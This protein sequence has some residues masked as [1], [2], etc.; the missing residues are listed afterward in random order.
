MIHPLLIYAA[1][2]MHDVR[3]KSRTRTSQ[4]RTLLNS[5]LF[6]RPATIVWQGRDIFDHDDLYP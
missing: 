3:Y 1:F 2:V 4:D 5:S 6:G